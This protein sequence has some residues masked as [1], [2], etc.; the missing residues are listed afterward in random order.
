MSKV[1]IPHLHF[2][3]NIHDALVWHGAAAAS[4][5]VARD[6]R[7]SSSISIFTPVS[8]IILFIILPLGPITSLIFSGSMLNWTIFG[9]YGER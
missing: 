3:Y 1:D 7:P 4:S 5:A 2:P 9:A 8:A 6:T